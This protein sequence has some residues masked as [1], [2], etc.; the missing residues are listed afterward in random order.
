[1]FSTGSGSFP[2]SRALDRCVRLRAMPSEKRPSPREPIGSK[3]RRDMC[4]ASRAAEVE[5]KFKV[6]EHPM[7]K[8]A[9]LIAASRLA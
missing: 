7:A 1:M 2:I 4:A 5:R 3:V 6:F 9:E 8:R